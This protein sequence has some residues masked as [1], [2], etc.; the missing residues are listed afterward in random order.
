MEHIF[1]YEDE[2]NPETGKKLKFEIYGTHLTGDGKEQKTAVSKQNI[3]I[4]KT[5]AEEN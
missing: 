3:T 4:G 2:I 1:A 5:T